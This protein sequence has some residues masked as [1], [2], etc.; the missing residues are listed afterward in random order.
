MILNDTEGPL[1]PAIEPHGAPSIDEMD[2]PYDDLLIE[3]LPSRP[4]GT[5]HVKLVYAGRSTP[6]PAESPWAEG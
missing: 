3:E 1:E 5:I 2:V 6:I 4:G